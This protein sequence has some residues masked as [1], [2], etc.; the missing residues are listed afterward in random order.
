MKGELT[1]NGTDAYDEWGMSLS[2]GA[3]STLMTPPPSKGVVTN[4]SRLFNGT[5]HVKANPKVDEHTISLELHFHASTKEKF[6]ANYQSFCTELE[7]GWLEIKTS[8]SSD[9]YRCHYEQCSQF[10]QYCQGLAKFTL[11]L[12]EMNPKNRG[13]EDIPNA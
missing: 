6:W 13:E 10:A 8:Y 1:I 5:I 11:K 3:L 9:I 12:T 2:D 7:K 4:K